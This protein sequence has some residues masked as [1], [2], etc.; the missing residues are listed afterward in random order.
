[1]FK[2]KQILVVVFHPSRIFILLI[3]YRINLL[4]PSLNI[5]AYGTQYANDSR[6]ILKVPK[7]PPNSSAEFHPPTFN[8]SLSPEALNVFLKLSQ[9]RK[10]ILTFVSSLAWKPLSVRTYPPASIIINSRKKCSHR[11]GV[12]GCSVLL[13]SSVKV[14]D[15]STANGWAHSAHLV[16]ADGH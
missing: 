8:G 9:S 11:L 2:S 10:P 13:E 12:V 14:H 6:F 4:S 5:S 7:V 16:R 3:L 15:V 1:M